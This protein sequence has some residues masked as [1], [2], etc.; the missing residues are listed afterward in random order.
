M[1]LELQ[2]WAQWFS[3]RLDRINEGSPYEDYT[4]YEQDLFESLGCD[5]EP[6][7]IP[8]DLTALK[9]WVKWQEGAAAP[10]RNPV[11][12]LLLRWAKGLGFH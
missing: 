5:L 9:A 2:I 8:E 10:V 12:E 1:L 4:G 6:Q 11:E 7:A 3:G